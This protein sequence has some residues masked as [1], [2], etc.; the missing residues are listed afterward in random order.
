VADSIRKSSMLR[1]G[2]SRRL[3]I[4]LKSDAVIIVTRHCL[5]ESDRIVCLE[6]GANDFII[7]PF[8]L[9]ELL[10]RVRAIL[11][12]QEMGRVAKSRDPEGGRRK[13]TGWQHEGCGRKLVDPWGTHR[14]RRARVNMPCY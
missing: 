9:R 12:E 1:Y 2:S 8:G 11:R 6:L 3:D 10:A 5:E 7:K 4:R 13:F 14:S